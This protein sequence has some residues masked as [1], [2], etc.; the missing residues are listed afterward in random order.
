MQ[1]MIWSK[2]NTNLLLVETQSG[3]ATVEDSW[4]YLIKL[5]TLLS[6]STVIILLGI[7]PKKW[8]TDIDTKP[9]HKC[10]YKLNL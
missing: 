1:A 4:L 3:T 5:R 9:A 6:C 7:D 8:E 10:S 2:S